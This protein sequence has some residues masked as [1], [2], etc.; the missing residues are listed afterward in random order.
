MFYL[1]THSTHCFIQLYGVGHI[2]KKTT[3]YNIVRYAKQCICL[4]SQGVVY[5]SLLSILED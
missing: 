1:M 4:Q 5:T 3:Q 2:V